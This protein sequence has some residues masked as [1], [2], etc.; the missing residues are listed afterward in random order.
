MDGQENKPIDDQIKHL[1]QGK[2]DQGEI[3]LFQINYVKAYLS[4]EGCHVEKE[5]GERRIR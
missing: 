4:G 2:N 3:A 1:A 5:E